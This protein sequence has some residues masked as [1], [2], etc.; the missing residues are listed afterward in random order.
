MGEQALEVVAGH[1]ISNDL[2]GI[3]SVLYQARHS[4]TRCYQ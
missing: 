4:R 3:S 1:F 2:A